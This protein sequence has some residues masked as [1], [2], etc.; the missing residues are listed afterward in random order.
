M[1]IPGYIRTDK[2]VADILFRGHIDIGLPH[3]GLTAET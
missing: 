1:R 3:L 2:S